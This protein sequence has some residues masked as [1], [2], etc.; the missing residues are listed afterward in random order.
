MKNIYCLIGN[1]GSGKT[2]IAD[3]LQREYNLSVLKSYTTRPKRTETD[4]DHIY[5][6]EEEYFALQHKV[7]TR[8]AKDGYYCATKEQID[9]HDIYV[10]DFGGF[11]ELKQKYDGHKS[12]KSIYVDVSPETSIERMRLRGDNADSIINRVKRDAEDNTNDNMNKVDYVVNG[13]E[14]L[15]YVKVCD[16]IVECERGDV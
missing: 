4:N 15:T 11:F 3:A 7:A 8:K 9:N 10:I 13:D 2:T 5:I 6:D 14:I 16:Y 1:S 12:V